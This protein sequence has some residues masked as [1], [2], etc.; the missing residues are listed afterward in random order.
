MIPG[1][2]PKKTTQQDQIDKIKKMDPDDEVALKKALKEA[3]LECYLQ[4]ENGERPV[5]GN[6]DNTYVNECHF[7]C[8]KRFKFKKNLKIDFYGDCLARPDEFAPDPMFDKF[9]KRH[10][11]TLYG[12]NE[13]SES[14]EFQE[15]DGNNLDEEDNVDGNAD[16]ELS[17]YRYDEK[18]GKKSFDEY[19]HPKDE[20]LEELGIPQ[21]F[22]QPDSDDEDA[23]PDKSDEA[24]SADTIPENEAD[25][26]K[27]LADY[28]LYKRNKKAQL[29]L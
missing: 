23:K 26:D 16:D 15:D 3:R 2:R 29:F 13:D 4:C 9:K 5:C 27:L 24:N 18:L 1:T 11:N 14:D 12:G 28:E 20:L 8:E 6:D 7:D 25:L 17:D 19:M 22:D 10:E 21:N